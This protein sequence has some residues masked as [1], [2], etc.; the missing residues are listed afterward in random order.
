MGHLETLEE[1]RDKKRLLQKI[2]KLNKFFSENKFKEDP[3]GLLVGNF[4]DFR[5]KVTP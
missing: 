5:I 4:F 3:L 1:Q 2:E